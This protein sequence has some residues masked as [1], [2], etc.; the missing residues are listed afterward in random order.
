[1][2]SF[3]SF[4]SYDYLN[5]QDLKKLHKKIE[6]VRFKYP[7]VNKFFYIATKWAEAV[8]C[9]KDEELYTLLDKYKKRNSVLDLK[10]GEIR[11][12]YRFIKRRDVEGIDEIE[13]MFKSASISKVDRTC[14]PIKGYNGFDYTGYDVE[15]MKKID[16]TLKKF[17]K[18]FIRVA[19]REDV[20]K[21]SKSLVAIVT[22]LFTI[23]KFIVPVMIM[24]IKKKHTPMSPKDEKLFKKHLKTLKKY[25]S[26]NIDKD[27]IED[28]IVDINNVFDWVYDFFNQ[29]KDTYKQNRN[30]R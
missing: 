21:A 23:S 14:T 13:D 16:S 29:I 6:D 3:K 4:S 26:G 1:M 5:E 11:E 7:G 22:T 8:S 18:E 25:E 20:I 2:K 28:A 9:G 27:H 19:T 24:V 15:N 10:D 30:S 17:A 12:V